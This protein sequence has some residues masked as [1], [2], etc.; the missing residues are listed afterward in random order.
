MENIMLGAYLMPKDL[1]AL[2]NAVHDEETFLEFLV[3]LSQDW[4]E[5]Q[6]IEKGKPSGPYSAGALGWENGSIG[7]ML[8]A[9]AAW[10][11]S[12]VHDAPRYEKSENPWRRAAHIIH[13][14]KFYE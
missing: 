6:A 4:E 1:F 7:P 5:E 8:D 2:A 11:T 13:A 10:G 9:A 3:A 12:T 14:G